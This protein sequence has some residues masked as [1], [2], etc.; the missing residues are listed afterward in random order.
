VELELYR[1]LAELNQQLEQVRDAEKALRIA[2]RLAKDHFAAAEACVAL[3][4]PAQEEA[5]PVY[6]L[7]KGNP[8]EGHLLASLSTEPPSRLPHNLLVAPI[9]RRERTWALLCL[10]RTQAKFGRPAIRAVRRVAGAISESIQ[11]IDRSRIADV[12]SRIDRKMMEQLRPQDLFYQILDGLRSLTRYDH[13]AAVLIHDEAPASLELVAEKIAWRKGKSDRIGSTVK[14][15]SDMQALME[16]GEVYGFDRT[17]AAWQEWRGR[18]VGALAKVLDYNPAE[19]RENSILCAPLPTRNGFL[20]VLKIASCES[21]SLGGYEAELVRRFLPQAAVAIQNLQRTESLQLGILEAEKK[22]AL[23]NLARG[24][25]HDINNAFGAV[26]P[27][28]QQ[29]IIEAREG[30]LDR[31]LLAQDLEQIES[32][33]R[34]CRR[35]FGGMLAFAR[36][37]VHSRSEGDVRRAVDSTLAILAEGIRRHAIRVTLNLS[38]PLPLVQGGQGDLE[39]LVLNLATNARDSMAEGGELAIEARP[40]GREVE[41]VLRDTGAGIP[42]DLLRRVQEPFF[43]TKR[44]GNGLGLSICRSIVWSLKG[45]LSIDS[46]PGEGTRV[47]VRLPAAEEKP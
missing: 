3:I 9:E 15:E 26:L 30:S 44:H 22:H 17:G 47:R 11:G 32:S 23:A 20:G 38:D 43:T 34:T 29:M 18:D 46:S 36:G 31:D 45:R 39:Q 1:F 40:V 37:A 19:K 28:V 35:I 10:R 6:V 7:P 33:V 27:L 14:I 8:W 21:G 41:I 4:H 16:S 42:A 24:V 12:R 2:L 13:S 5:A 25:T